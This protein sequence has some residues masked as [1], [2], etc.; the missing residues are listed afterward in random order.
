MVTQLPHG[1]FTFSS[2]K[3]LYCMGMGAATVLANGEW[4]RDLR[5]PT[6]PTRLLP[7]RVLTL[8]YSNTVA[9]L[10]FSSSKRKY[11]FR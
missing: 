11:A 5:E 3:N 6:C 8:D 2:V 10:F 4:P 9:E 7:C 1:E